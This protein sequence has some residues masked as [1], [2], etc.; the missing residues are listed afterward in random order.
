MD[1]NGW[2]EAGRQPGQERLARLAGRQ[3]GG[4]A[5][6]GWQE[7]CSNFDETIPQTM[8]GLSGFCTVAKAQCVLV[9][10]RLDH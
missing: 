3:A 9:F 1:N 4:G 5:G 6:A 8:S 2:P 10:G 7:I